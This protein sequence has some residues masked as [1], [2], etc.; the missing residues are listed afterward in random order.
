M[1]QKFD[2][3]TP[4]LKFIYSEKA[5]KLCKISTLLL[6]GTTEDKSKVKIS[7]NFVAFSDYMNFNTM[8]KKDCENNWRKPWEAKDF[9]ANNLDLSDEQ[10]TCLQMNT[11]H[12]GY[13]NVFIN[14]IR[15]PS[16][17]TIS[18]DKFNTIDS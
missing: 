3:I 15:D 6:T 8:K 1:P 9:K 17:A 2:K 7:Q 16:L 12:Q 5:A 14:I 13:F 4:F 11:G 10:V 18:Q